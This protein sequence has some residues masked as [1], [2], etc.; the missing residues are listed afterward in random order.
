MGAHCGHGVWGAE[1]LFLGGW[2]LGSGVDAEEVGGWGLR[3]GL[4]ATG[5]AL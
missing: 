3:Q 2:G 1:S 4:L 5:S